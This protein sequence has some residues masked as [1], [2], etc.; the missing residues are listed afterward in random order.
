V[1]RSRS[2]SRR[3]ST[4][5][6]AA[7]PPTLLSAAGAPQQQ[8][9]AQPHHWPVESVNAMPMYAGGVAPFA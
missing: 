7:R 4:R 8:A 9:R 5:A 2:V 6:S 3:A 1:S